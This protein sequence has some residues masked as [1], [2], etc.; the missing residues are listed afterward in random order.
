MTKQP[1]QHIAPL[2]T[3]VEDPRIASGRR[4]V[5]EVNGSVYFESFLANLTAE[6]ASRA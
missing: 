5:K 3:K 6:T 4:G 2:S 1:E